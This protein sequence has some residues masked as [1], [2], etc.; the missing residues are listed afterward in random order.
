ML[1]LGDRHLQIKVE[2]KKS[3][4]NFAEDIQ[5]EPS[6][7]RKITSYREGVDRMLIGR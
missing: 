5:S 7:F 6:I 3:L 2:L 1:E 4:L